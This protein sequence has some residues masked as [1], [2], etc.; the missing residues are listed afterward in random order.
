MQLG[1]RQAKTVLIVISAARVFR[2]SPQFGVTL[3]TYE[4]V[5]SVFKV[6]F[7]K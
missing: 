5:Q 3:L 6:D 4:F 7:K 2:S 1:P